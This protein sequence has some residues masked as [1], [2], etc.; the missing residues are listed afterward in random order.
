MTVRLAFSADDF[1][2]RAKTVTDKFPRTGRLLVIQA[3][4]N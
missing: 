3:A 2:V 1:E 4:E